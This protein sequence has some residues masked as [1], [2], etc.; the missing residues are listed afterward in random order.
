MLKNKFKLFTVFITIALIFTTS[1]VFADEENTADLTVTS[2][3]S[4][5]T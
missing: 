1:F 3:D 2:E 4:A 5:T